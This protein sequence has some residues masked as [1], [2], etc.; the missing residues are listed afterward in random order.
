MQ[1]SEINLDFSD[2]EETGS[3]LKPVSKITNAQLDSVY[4]Q[5]NTIDEVI[6]NG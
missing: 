1:N 4:R 3:L 2:D 6:R 5:G